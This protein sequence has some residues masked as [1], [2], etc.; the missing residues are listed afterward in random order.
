LFDIACK[1]YNKATWGKGKGVAEEERI[2][3]GELG[4]ESRSNLPTAQRWEKK[5]GKSTRL[6]ST[7]A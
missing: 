6:F 2:G 4:M 5:S 7:I 1:C 3:A